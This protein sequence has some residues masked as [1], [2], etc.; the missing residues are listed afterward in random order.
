M[1]TT[2]F[3]QVGSN[4]Q[5]QLDMKGMTQQSLADSLN[6]S[7]QVMNKIIKGS[8]D[9]GVIDPPCGKRTIRMKDR[10]KLNAIQTAA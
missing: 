5:K 7:K 6:I 8:K 3:V 4:I 2:D 10:A 9:A 1:Y